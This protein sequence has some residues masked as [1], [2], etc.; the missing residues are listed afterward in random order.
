LGP[1]DEVVAT[2]AEHHSNLVPWQEAAR[3]RGFALRFIGL[4]EDGQLDLARLDGVVTERTRLV[5]VTGLSN[6]LGTVTDLAPLAGAARATGALLL[7][8]GA[9]LIAHE[10][11]DVAASGIDF[12]C[13]SGHKVFGPTGVGVLAARPE[14][15][16]EMPPFLAGGEM[17]LDVT[18]DGARWNE[19]PY[20]FEAGTPPV[21]EVLGL[22]AALDRLEAIGIDA[23]RAH[24]RALLEHG[25]RA[26]SRVPGLVL[27]AGGAPLEHRVPIFAF[28]LFDEGGELI[29][30]H[31]VA[32]I[33]SGEGIAI[34]AGHHCARP[35]ARLLGVPAS[36]RASCGPYNTIE[37]L[38]ALAA[39]LARAR[40]FFSRRRP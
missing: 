22:C 1:G 17:V 36:C 27:Y 38:D 10:K 40:S 31:D 14:L 2:V 5:C 3:E 11:V 4:A 7:V 34:R 35:L 26:L 12:L 19:V 13:F 39:G 21:A 37:E 24:G 15:L 28:N 25:A 18:L 30:P 32:T 29:H 33:L 8:D 6:V 23:V 20:K 9:Q 16:E